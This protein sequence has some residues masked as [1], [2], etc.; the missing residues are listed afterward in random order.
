MRQQTTSYL[1][2]RAT[3]VPAEFQH[4]F[5]VA[6]CALDEQLEQLQRQYASATR[7]ASRAKFEFELLEKRAGTPAHLL[8]TAKRQRA[9]AE[10]RCARL[11]RA[12]DA[13][14]ERL[15]NE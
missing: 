14:E 1:D 13:L 7:A 9:A 11:I 15:E 12:I 6:E 4:D 3:Y 8:A 2:S 10:T 5:D